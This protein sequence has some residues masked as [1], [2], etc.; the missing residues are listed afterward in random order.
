MS[1][2]EF[3]VTFSSNNIFTWIFEWIKAA[4]I[5]IDLHLL[6]NEQHTLTAPEGFIFVEKLAIDVNKTI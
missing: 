6:I 2:V 4:N 5:Q 3:C 1:G